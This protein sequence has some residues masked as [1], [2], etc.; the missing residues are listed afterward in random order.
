M[1]K[2]IWKTPYLHYLESLISVK[3]FLKPETPLFAKRLS[4]GISLAERFLKM[5]KVLVK[6]EVEYL[7]NQFSKFTKRICPK[8]KKKSKRLK[9]IFEV[10]VLILIDHI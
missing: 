5:E 6:I 2:N 4:S 8:R 7:R 3:S 1:T 10:K 9:D